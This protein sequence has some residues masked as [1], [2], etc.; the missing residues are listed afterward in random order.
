VCSVLQEEG[1]GALRR[2]LEGAIGAQVRT[3]WFFAPQVE[4]FGDGFWGALVKKG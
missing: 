3:E 2:L 1:P 4:P